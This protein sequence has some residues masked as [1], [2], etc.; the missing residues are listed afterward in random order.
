VTVEG[1]EYVGE[2][3]CIEIKT[4]QHY[5][6]LVRTVKSEQKVSVLCWCVVWSCV[7]ACVLYLPNLFVCTYHICKEDILKTNSFITMWPT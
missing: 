1:I 3:G 4:E 5:I 7:Y 6:Q 2:E